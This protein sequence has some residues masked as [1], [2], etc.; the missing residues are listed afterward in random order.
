LVLSS[1]R[2]SL[3]VWKAAS[4]IKSQPEPPKE[5]VSTPNPE[6]PNPSAELEILKPQEGSVSLENETVVQGITNPNS[7]IIIASDEN[8]YFTKAKAS[9]EFQTTIDLVGG[10]NQFKVFSVTETS[11]KDLPI[12]I[13]HTTEIDVENP[14]DKAKLTNYKGTIT[15]ISEDTLQTK[16]S[17]GEINQIVIS[18]DTTYSN[19][20]KHPKKNIFTDLAIGDFIVAIGPKNTNK[21][22]EAKRVLVSLPPKD[23][24]ITLTL[25]NIETDD[26]DTSQKPTFYTVN[27]DGILKKSS[28]KN[29]TEGQFISTGKTVFVIQ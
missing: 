13:V 3:G 28:L 6:S 5:Q 1:A 15:D 11:V 25:G 14:Q 9:G 4:T 17:S 24:S 19:I 18:T 7:I 12:S 23:L 21:V 2:S 16:S 29:I 20:I 10:I 22:L 26:I 8:D 27:P